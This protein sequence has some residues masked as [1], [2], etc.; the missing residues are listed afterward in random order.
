MKK[1]LLLVACVAL[2]FSGIGQS[3][4][5]EYINPGSGYTNVVA[6]T[7]GNIKTLY[8]AGQVGT[9][10]SLEEQIRTSFAGVIKQLEDAGAA[11]TDVVK[12][13]TYIV[14]YREE[15]L[16]VFRKVRKELFG[17][18]NMPANTL[19]GV[20]SLATDDFKVEMEAVAVVAVD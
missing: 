16:D 17:D 4:K 19:V 7:T 20:T 15:D 1:I 5:K 18:Q 11:F 9:G 3:L 8:I 2:S 14:N 6:V 12:M 13:N 10:D